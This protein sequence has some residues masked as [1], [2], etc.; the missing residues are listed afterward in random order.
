MISSVKLFLHMVQS[1]K[2]KLQSFSMVKLDQKKKFVVF[3]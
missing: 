3:L 2:A 1:N